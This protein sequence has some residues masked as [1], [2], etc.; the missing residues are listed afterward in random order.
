MA[1]PQ[2]PAA[3]RLSLAWDSITEVA[4]PAL[5]RSRS[6][7]GATAGGLA[8]SSVPLIL[9][10]AAGLLCG[11][12]TRGSLLCPATWSQCPERGTTARPR[13]GPRPQF[14]GGP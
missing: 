4:L 13:V 7:Y 9:V 5:A 8:A 2:P 6:F 14:G 10:D 3:D 11:I 1:G 12:L